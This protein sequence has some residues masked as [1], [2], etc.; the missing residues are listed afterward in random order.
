ML[1]MLC[2]ANINATR[3]LEDTVAKQDQKTETV[4]PVP[5]NDNTQQQTDA[6][7]T[8]KDSNQDVNESQVIVDNTEHVQNQD[9]K[10]QNKEAQEEKTTQQ[11]SEVPLK[12]KSDDKNKEAVQ[13][14]KKK[15]EPQVIIPQE[16]KKETKQ[17]IEEKQEDE[18]IISPTPDNKESSYFG[19]SFGFILILAASVLFFFVGFYR[20]S[21]RKYKIP[22]FTPPNF[23]P[24]FLFPRPENDFLMEDYCIQ[25]G[26]EIGGVY[27]SEKYHNFY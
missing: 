25:S 16:E 14:E 19:L 3:F 13:E 10:D 15:E 11:K 8:E 22:P 6:N 7:S 2:I 23:C 24:N 9:A 1:V 4:Q 27:S 26:A 17:E 18:K 5:Q 12:E 21:L 20:Y